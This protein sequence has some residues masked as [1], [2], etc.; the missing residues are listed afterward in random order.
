MRGGDKK[1]LHVDMVISNVNK[2][3]RNLIGQVLRF[4]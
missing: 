4:M 3:G 2:T 1:T